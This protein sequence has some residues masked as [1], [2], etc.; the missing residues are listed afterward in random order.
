MTI[1][2]ISVFIENKTGQLAEFISLLA[3]NNIDLQALSM[4]EAQDYGVLRI[5]VDKP[6]ETAEL[7]R[8]NEWPCSVTDVLAVMVPDKPGSLTKIL[9][10]IAEN[11]VSL[12]Y[13][14]AFLSK[15]QGHACVVLRVDDNDGVQKI[16]ENAGVID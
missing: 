13:S 3:S 9:S 7:L 5:V 4:A 8:A 16:L 11:N 2:Q 6:E 1:K 10:V 12:A 15:T 14:Y